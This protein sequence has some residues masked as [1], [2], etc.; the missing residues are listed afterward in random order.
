MRPG[1]RPAGCLDLAED[2]ALSLAGFDAAQFAVPAIVNTQKNNPGENE[3][4]E[5]G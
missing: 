3:A 1:G 4:H 5:E 2:K